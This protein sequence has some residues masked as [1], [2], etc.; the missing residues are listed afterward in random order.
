VKER[1]R[2]VGRFLLAGG[3]AA[4]ANWSSRFV[5]SEYFGYEV[6]VVLAF[7][8]GLAVGFV[9]M[10]GWVFEAR[11]RSY[12]RQAVYYVL[13][14]LV[15]LIQ[16]FFISVL[17]AKWV[18]PSVGV[19]DAAEGIAHLVGVLVPVASSYFGHKFI[20]FK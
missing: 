17:L 13:V 12:P 15:A 3:V 18:L 9:L 19:N 4:L 20:T 5:F 6:A 2:G 10:R 8:V 16:T 1:F 7:F 11:G 14:N